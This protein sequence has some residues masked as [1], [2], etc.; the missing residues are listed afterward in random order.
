MK[1][2]AK[3]VGVQTRKLFFSYHFW[4]GVPWRPMASLGVPPQNVV[5]EHTGVRHPTQKYV[6]GSPIVQ[7]SDP[8]NNEHRV[9]DLG[10]VVAR[11]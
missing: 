5:P 10:G 1:R 4:H 3:K 8:D 11:F 7:A 9:Q 2:F 6:T